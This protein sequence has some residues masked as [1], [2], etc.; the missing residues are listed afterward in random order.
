VTGSGS[1][2]A[3]QR[4]DLV[5]YD[6]TTIYWER[7]AE[8]GLLRRGHSKDHRPHRSQAVLGLLLFAGGLRLD[9]GGPD[10]EPVRLEESLEGGGGVRTLK[11]PLELRPVYQW[12]W[13]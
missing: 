2:P 6:T 10:V 12:S 8:D 3:R 7:E 9:R 4:F 5:L 13:W 11:S 1:P